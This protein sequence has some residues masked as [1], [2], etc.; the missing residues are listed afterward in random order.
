[1]SRGGVV[2]GSYA[3]AG[4]A[5]TA[6]GVGTTAAQNAVAVGAVSAA[7]GLGATAFGTSANAQKTDS[8]AIG[9][10]SNSTS[11]YGVAVGSTAVADSAD[12]VALGHSARALSTAPRSVAL[13]AGTTADRAGMAGGK[14]LFS[15]TTVASTQGAVSVGSAG[16]E[17]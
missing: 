11:D 1:M 15:K 4:G 2:L 14:E 8:L 12:S 5:A 10:W 7:S 16:M 17:R 13:G 6:I 9:H 3:T